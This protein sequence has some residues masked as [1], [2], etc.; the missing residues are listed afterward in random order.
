VEYLEVPVLLRIGRLT[1]QGSPVSIFAEA[2]PALAIK[3][4]CS[5][6]YNDTSG[7]CENGVLPGQDWRIGQADVS[8]ILGLGGAL[9]IR[10]SVVMIGGRIDWGLRD[11]GGG[12]GVP[13]KN[14]S[15]LL[16]AGLLWDVHHAH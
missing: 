4:R 14:R 12:S 2:G 10:R 16:Y 9:R 3:A 11:I 1:Y 6:L 7:G 5:M 15:S 13:T 8:G